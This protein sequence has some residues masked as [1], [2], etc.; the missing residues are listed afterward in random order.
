MEVRDDSVLV[1][2]VQRV[3]IV[4]GY[5]SSPD[6]NW[7]PRLQTAVETE[8][9]AMAVVPLPDPEN[10]DKASWEDAV[11]VALGTPD[12]ATVVVAHSLGRATNLRAEYS[13]FAELE[14][15]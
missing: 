14:K 11:S 6:A 1:R 9:I 5:E 10:P 7:F 12:A 15:V 3:V 13:T 2:P 4:H 8:G